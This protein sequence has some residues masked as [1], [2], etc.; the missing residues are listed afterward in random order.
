MIN[1]TGDETP[2]GLNNFEIDPEN[3][4]ISDKEKSRLEF[5]SE[6]KNYDPDLA[7]GSAVGICADW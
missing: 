3:N 6:I 5:R 1:K 4:R 2:I 7:S